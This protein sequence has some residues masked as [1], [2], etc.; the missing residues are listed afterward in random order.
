MAYT[1]EGTGD[2]Q[3]QLI[4]TGRRERLRAQALK[5]IKAAALSHLREYGAADLSLRAVARDAGISAP[6]LYRYFNGRD[7]LLTA[8]IADG[9]NDLA[10]HL[11]VAVG[12]DPSA[13]SGLDRRPPQP[14]ETVTGSA[15]IADRLRAACRA[16]REWAVTHPNEFGLIYGD[17]IPGY[18]APADG[19]TVRANRR[20][21][22]LLGGLVIEAFASGRARVPDSFD[23]PELRQKL[24]PL[25]DDMGADVDGPALGAMLALW[26]RLH[27]IIS[28]E[29]F[30][31]LA[32]LF[33]DDASALFEAELATML[34]QL[35]V[36]ELP[37]VVRLGAK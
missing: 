32:W 21:G 27:G 9:Y 11:A 29:A 18:A 3:G 35:G 15:D 1:L 34:D 33:E 26:S 7:E 6:G 36:N 2:L 28:L 23:T 19:E 20:V 31:H 8:L 10:D 37:H 22:L 16:Y 14:D 4:V 5:D 12:M 30:G 17:P 25:V 24:A 13:L